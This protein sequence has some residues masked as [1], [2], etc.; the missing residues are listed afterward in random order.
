VKIYVRQLPRDVTTLEIYK[1]F[2]PFGQICKVEILSE[3]N[4]SWNK[5]AEVLFK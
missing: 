3:S 2:E 1:H 5:R 4:A